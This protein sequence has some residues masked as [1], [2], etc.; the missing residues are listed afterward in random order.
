MHNAA[1]PESALPPLDVRSLV[2]GVAEQDRSVQ[3]RNAAIVGAV[4]VMTTVLAAIFG[5][6][7]GP[8][9]GPMLT[10][11]AATWSMLDLFTSA[12]LF[13]RFY[14]TRRPLFGIIAA[15]FALTGLLT[16]PYI[17]AYAA[18]SF[19][20]A[21]LADQQVFPALY[22]TWRAL[23][24]LLIITAVLY[25]RRGPRTV[26]VEAIAADVAWYAGAAVA[27]ALI[28][29][30][31]LIAARSHL[32][33]MVNGSTF[34]APYRDVLLPFLAVLNA[35]GCA[36]LL[37]RKDRFS[38]LSLWLLVA[39]LAALLDAL[40]HLSAPQRWSYAWD[41]GK[42]LTLVSATAVL[43]RAFGTLL[44]MYGGVSH[45]VAAR[46]ARGASRIRALWHIVTSAGFDERDHLQMVLDTAT[47]Q[48]RPTRAAFGCLSHLDGGRITIDVTSTYPSTD[49]FKEDVA[50]YV[51]GSSFPIDDLHADLLAAPRSR[52]WV[53]TNPKERAVLAKRGW[54]SA[55]GTTIRF[56]G[57]TYFIIF[58]LRG[59]NANDPLSES[60]VAFLEVVG[61][62]ISQ[63]FH[64]RAQVERLQYH[65]EH[66][67]L[68]GLHN[69]KHFRVMGRT[70][71]AE[72]T[73]AGV[74]VVDLDHYGEVNRMHGQVLGDEVLVE[75]G[76]ALQQVDEKNLAAR[77][78]G[79]EFGILL[80]GH[81]G[82]SPN[83][84]QSMRAYE[85][86]FDQPF[87]TGDREGAAL[88]QVTASIG[89]AIW[90]PHTGF[91]DV[92]ARADVALEFSKQAGGHRA[93][94]FGPALEALRADRAH[95]RDQL[96][97]ALEA[98]E[99]TLEYQ[100]MFEMNSRELAGAEA[101]VRWRHPS[102]GM[103]YP[104]SF[105]PTMQRADL[106]GSLTTWVMHR[107]V[108]D[109][110][111]LRL[112]KGFRCY[113]NV[114]SL[115]LESEPFLQEIAGLISAHPWLAESLGLEITE[116]EAMHD[117]DRAVEALTR[118]RSLGLLASVDDFGT[119]YSSLAYLKRLP[120]DVLKLDKSFIAGIPN[121]EKD[122]AL[123]KLFLDVAR[124]F[125][126]V[127]VAEG[128]E[129]EE[130]AFWLRDQGCM[131]GQGYLLG[132]PVP[133]GTL[134]AMLSVP[135]A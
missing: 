88:L 8:Q 50:H 102:R 35:G 91:E 4:L 127:S 37:T 108:R 40:L 106:M 77:I 134:C 93:T 63:R 86:L 117:I 58:G 110:D 131:I 56:G 98:D 75:V 38:G 7:S 128:I 114:P 54:S 55:L 57:R 90:E 73:L 44:R 120:I 97:Q 87:H 85:R 132:R 78:G 129:T 107:I 103:L 92:L 24:P 81:G 41:V 5:R 51:T 82:V 83:A 9:S 68:T 112:P 17:A 99:F 121:N 21:T 1:E 30:Y 74:I 60:D 118:V 12:L 76:A 26:P 65:Q 11:V 47:S 48:L 10:A 105:L 100:P 33:V 84:E 126:L 31:G 125:A 29:S 133:I 67:G 45:I 19:V 116:T 69:R 94:L 22:V 64:E 2:L 115:V 53:D 66:D 25:E 13:G 122:T 32:P 70:A 101:L 42:L 3:Q 89:A 135:S 6:A 39:M 59:R 124:Q 14:V 62:Y 46:T 28:V 119:G 72:G 34:E 20:P 130:Q 80:Y 52:V 15:A 23:F 104:A 109:F 16:W 113:F 43:A 36:A 61:A 111:A 27:A 49:D 95:Q 71:V 96:I 79:D 123:A 18:Y